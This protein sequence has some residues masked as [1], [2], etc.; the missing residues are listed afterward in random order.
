MDLAL[1]AMGSLL[2]KLGELLSEEYKMQTSVKRDVE[3]FRN[4]F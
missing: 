2:P 3:A 1:G 4:D